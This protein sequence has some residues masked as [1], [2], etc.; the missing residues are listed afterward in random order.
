MNTICSYVATINIPENYVLL[1]TFSPAY[2]WWSPMCIL[3]MHYHYKRFLWANQLDKSYL[4]G[5]YYLKGLDFIFSHLYF[6]PHWS[7][8]PISSNLISQ[9]LCPVDL[10]MKSH[11]QTSS[12]FSC[13][14]TSK[15][16]FQFEHADFSPRCPT[17]PCNWLILSPLWWMACWSNQ[18]PRKYFSYSFVS[19]HP[20]Q[21]FPRHRF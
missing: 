10:T 16:L 8:Y 19:Y 4:K 20:H 12:C 6:S 14:Q 17:Y 7:S 21:I 5:G 15:L 9:L 3:L 11:T 13:L 2:K 18:N 1:F